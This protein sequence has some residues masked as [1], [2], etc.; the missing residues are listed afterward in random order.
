MAPKARPPILLPTD[1]EDGEEGPVV[2]THKGSNQSGMRAFNERLLLSLVRRHGAIAKSDVARITGLSAQTA[3]VIMRALEADDLI[4]RGEPVRGRVGQ[5]S[6]PLSLN[7]DGAYFLGLKVGRRSADFVL[8][9]FL[10]QVLSSEHRTY[11]YPVPA[12][13]IRFARKAIERARKRLGQR[14]RRISGV[15]IAMPF[16]LWNWA[17]EVGAPAKIMDK[18]RTLDL[19]KALAEF[20]PWQIYVQ[21]DA[22]AACGAELAFGSRRL[23]QDF[24]YFYVGTLVGG[25]VVLNG[26]LYPGR[27]GNAGAYGSMLVPSPSGGSVQLIDVASLVVLE[28]RLRGD[29]IDPESMWS[30][31]GDWGQ[32]E[33]QAEE[34]LENAAR[35]LAHAI[36]SAC[37]TIDFELAMIDGGYPAHFRQRMLEQVKHEIS[38]LD[39]QGISV[40]P[41]VAG[42]LGPI[43]RALGG[44]SLP[45]FDRFLIDQN[46]LMREG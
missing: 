14:S 25:G 1:R 27:T 17:E 43:A 8:V 2:S 7:P 32:F 35:G 22:T 33:A 3:S 21:N 39:T 46:I 15:G 29:G 44:P 13:V 42:T 37:S 9:N 11:P 34:W 12:D 18:W 38:R 30:E 16:E 36:V 10:G 6:V 28:R 41:L 26:S 23:P 40:P 45:L 31:S 20:C 4:Q 19:G 5:P 24:V